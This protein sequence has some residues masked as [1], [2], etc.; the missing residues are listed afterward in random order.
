MEPRS[1]FNGPGS[2]IW[3]TPSPLKSL[4][5]ELYP[6]TS[7][8]SFFEVSPAT[9]NFGKHGK[10]FWD[11]ILQILAHNQNQHC[12][13]LIRSILIHLNQSLTRLTENSRAFISPHSRKKTRIY[14][15]KCTIFLQLH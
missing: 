1:N 9:N 10:V 11:P 15:T 14:E 5:K 8:S 12:S 4:L 6:I 3:R 13:D 2:N 7:T